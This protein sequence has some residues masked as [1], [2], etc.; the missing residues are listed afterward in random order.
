[1]AMAKLTDRLLSYKP[2]GTTLTLLVGGLTL[3]AAALRLYKL[4]Q[5]SFWIDEM[6]SIQDSLTLELSPQIL[7]EKFHFLYFVANRPLLVALGVN[8]WNARIAAAIIGILTV[9]LI[10][11]I[12]HRLFGTTVAFVTA[13]LLAVAPWHLYWSQNAR[14]YTMLLLFYSLAFFSFHWGLETNRARYALA[15][16]LFWGL[17]M[18]SHPTAAV[19]VPIFVLYIILVKAL[20][21]AEPP[22]FNRRY[23]APFLAMPVLY[24]ALELLRFAGGRNPLFLNILSRFVRV[25]DFNLGQAARLS[26]GVI[27]YIGVPLVVLA[28]VGATY[29]LAQRR[30]EGLLLLIGALFPMLLLLIPISF[31]RYAFISLPCWLIL[32]AVALN[33][34]FSAAD[35]LVKLLAFG[36][37]LAFVSVS[38]SELYLYYFVHEG[39]RGDFKGAFHTVREGEQAGDRVV[40]T[41]AELGQYYLGR[42]VLPVG[43]VQVSELEESAGRVW[44]VDSEDGEWLNPRVRRW[45]IENARLVDVRDIHTNG[46]V[47]ETRV[48]LYEP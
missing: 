44:Y 11:F 3:L 33:A 15:A 2:T 48:Y 6:Y 29:L 26:A 1:M 5:W 20:P 21:F 28:L 4:D 43:D 10:Y 30:R 34:L 9:P 32:A 14:F 35:Q 27:I 46:N 13:L 12:V 25:A 8:E 42:S 23:L 18:L 31:T 39:R 37:L 17:A 7:A 41:W 38:A 40:A 47:Y 16:A 36:I 22:G 19:L 24:V 45:M